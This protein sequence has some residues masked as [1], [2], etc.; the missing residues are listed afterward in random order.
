MSFNWADYLEL[1]KNLQASPAIPGPEEASLRSA[2]SRA[3]YAVY[4]LAMEFAKAENYAPYHT[5]DDHQ[6]LVR[7]FRESGTDQARKRISAELDRMRGSTSGRLRTQLRQ[8][9][10]AMADLTI[11]REKVSSKY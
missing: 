7:Y 5:G 4:Q 3:Y 9:P 10:R 1:A 11:K 8:S 6:G 2:T